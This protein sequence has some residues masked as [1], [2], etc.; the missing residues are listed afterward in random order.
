[1][2]RSL[3]DFFETV[4]IEPCKGDEADRETAA[5]ALLSLK[6][7]RVRGCLMALKDVSLPPNLKTVLPLNLSFAGADRSQLTEDLS[8]R[9]RTAS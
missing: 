1:M 9:E 7:N 4:R 6:V 3:V 5:S 2:G 8:L